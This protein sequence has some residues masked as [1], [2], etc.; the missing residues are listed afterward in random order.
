MLRLHTYF[1]SSAAYRVRIALNLKGLA[2][3]MA[4]VHLAK[5]GGRQNASSYTAINPQALVPTLEIDGD[6]LTQSLAI[7]GYLDETRP[8]PPLLPKDPLARAK[9]R[10]FALAIAC[11]VHPLNNLRVLQY[12]KKSMGHDQAAIDGWY[13]HWC[14]TGLAACEAMLPQ[15]GAGPYSFG[16][17]PTVADICLVPQM[18][19]ARRFNCDLTK[20]PRLVAIDAACVAH[21]AFARAAP[22]AQGDAE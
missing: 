18:A 20:I 3:E 19:N 4:Y 13:R 9:V 1:R 6:R 5:D 15:S 2:P 12:L 7:I 10:A 14:E 21:E 11:E 8:D 22:S 17:A 16:A